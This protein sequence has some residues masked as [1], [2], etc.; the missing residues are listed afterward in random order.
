MNII[1]KPSVLASEDL[2]FLGITRSLFDKN[3]AVGSV[4]HLCQ[5]VDS[6]SDMDIVVGGCLHLMV[7]EVIP[8]LLKGEG[9]QKVLDLLIIAGRQLFPR[10][11]VYFV[12]TL[13]KVV[14]EDQKSRE[15]RYVEVVNNAFSEVAEVAQL[16]DGMCTS[17]LRK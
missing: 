15:R 8:G 6:V 7:K 14:L 16:S 1:E 3:P 5:L 13:L 12:D 2:Q 9:L 4:Q 10:V 17:N 11:P